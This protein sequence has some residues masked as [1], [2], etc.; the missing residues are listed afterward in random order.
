[1]GRQMKWTFCYPSAPLY[2]P[3]LLSLELGTYDVVLLGI[4]KLEWRLS[5]GQQTACGAS[6]QHLGP[7]NLC[8]E[9]GS[10]AWAAGR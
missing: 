3:S 10:N 9:S 8:G 2:Q 4:E 5:D 7:R 6:G 1:M